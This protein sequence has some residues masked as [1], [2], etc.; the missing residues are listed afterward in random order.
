MK[1]KILL[2][3][4][5]ICMVLVM[6]PTMAFADGEPAAPPTTPPTENVVTDPA[7]PANSAVVTPEAPVFT[8]STVYIFAEAEHPMIK[9]TVS[10]PATA[11]DR[12][13]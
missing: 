8:D 2:S 10:A 3:V 13:W 6:M 7:P 11:G 12:F 5:C 4:L 9:L 1:K